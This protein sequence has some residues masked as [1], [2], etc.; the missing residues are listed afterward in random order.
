MGYD[1]PLTDRGSSLSG[2]QQQRIALARAVLRSPAVLLL[3]EATNQLDAAT[4]Q[5]VLA[6]LAQLRSTRIVIAHRLSTIARADLI[7]TLQ[8]G[9]IA[10]QG[11]HAE[12]LSRNGVYASLVAAQTGHLTHSPNL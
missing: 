6:Q 11:T 9:T 4:E 1:T 8:D 2:G 10:E 12:L 5:L 7:V 3:D